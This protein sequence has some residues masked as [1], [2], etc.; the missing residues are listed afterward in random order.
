MEEPFLGV[1]TQYQ[2]TTGTLIGPLPFRAG[3]VDPLAL[4]IWQCRDLKETNSKKIMKVNIQEAMETGHVDWVLHV[5]PA[6]DHEEQNLEVVIRNGQFFFQAVRD[7]NK[8]EELVVW[9]GVDVVEILRLPPVPSTTVK[10]GTRYFCVLCHKIFLHPYPVIGH[11]MYWCEKRNYVKSLTTTPGTT[12]T[13]LSTNIKL[14][15]TQP[16]IKRFDIASLTDTS[17]SPSNQNVANSINCDQ[18]E[19]TENLSNNIGE[20][21]HSLKSRIIVKRI[22]DTTDEKIRGKKRQKTIVEEPLT[23]SPPQ[24]RT[25]STSSSPETIP[26]FEIKMSNSLTASE[27]RDEN[28]YSII[29]NN[30]TLREEMHIPVKALSAFRQVKKEFSNPIF[31]S[32]PVSTVASSRELFSS[33]L[34]LSFV[35]E[36]SLSRSSLTS[37][38]LDDTQNSL[39]LSR[40]FSDQSFTEDTRNVLSTKL[41]HSSFDSRGLKLGDLRPWSISNTNSLSFQHTQLQNI[42][43]SSSKYFSTHLNSNVPTTKTVA[44]PI[45]SYFPQTLT[46]LPFPTQNWCA[47]CNATFRMTSDLVYH[48]RTHHKREPIRVK[49]KR[50]EKL[51]CT[52]CNESF[53]ERHHLTRHMTSHQ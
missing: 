9:F 18:D 20:D 32:L 26:A 36:L 47:K 12:D 44:P 16:R 23:F 41:F 52:L 42:P 49:T 45:I 17:Y 50:E 24:D 25:K 15:Q 43:L 2:V 31:P 8:E 30:K 21:D 3:A 13:K 5:R 29:N 11:L 7:I 38:T 53:R 22:V 19:M 27:Q 37:N 51:K 33:H 48:M 40:G 6:R 46:A 34:E 1:A 35:P 28:S 4:L 14:K 10:E 39:A